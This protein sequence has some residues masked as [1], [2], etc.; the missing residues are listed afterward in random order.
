MSYQQGECVPLSLSLFITMLIDGLHL[1]YQFF[2]P[3]SQIKIIWSFQ[4]YHHSRNKPSTNYL[5]VQVFEIILP[6]LR[7]QLVNKLY[8]N[9]PNFEIC[10]LICGVDLLSCIIEKWLGAWV[11]MGVRGTNQI[12]RQ[13]NYTR[14][15][16][17]LYK[18]WHWVHRTAARIFKWHQN[19]EVRIIIQSSSWWGSIN[20]VLGKWDGALIWLYWFPWNFPIPI[21]TNEMNSL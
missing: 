17:L 12:L 6:I 2:F 16:S 5:T 3:S 8:C 13:K 7:N 19:C 20:N 21:H 10:G 11:Q 4:P 18:L 9:W 14:M 15:V 1:V